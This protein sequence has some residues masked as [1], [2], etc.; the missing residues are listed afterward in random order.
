MP[1][2]FE[3]DF[4]PQFLNGTPAA[5][6]HQPESFRFSTKGVL[7]RERIKA[8]REL[9]DRGIVPIEPLPDRPVHVDISKWFLP[10]LGILSGTL[11]GLRQEGTPRTENDDL[12]FGFNVAGQCNIVQRGREISPGEGDAFLLNLAAGCFAISRP[13]LGHFVGLRVPRNAITPLVRD[14]DVT[15]PRSIPATADSAKLLGCYLGGL[16]RG[17]LLTIPETAQL[18]VTHVHDLI[19]LSLGAAGNAGGLLE[20]RTVAAV[21]LRAIKSDIVAHL[22]EQDLTI[23]AIAARHG[24]TPRYVHR[25]FEREGI[26]YTQFVLRQRLERAYRM[27]RDPRF[28]MWSIS[29]VAYEVGFGDL[30]YF[31]RA[32]RRH[33]QLTPSDVKDPTRR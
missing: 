1:C 29:A 28:A 14:I 25:L 27:L 10:G 7:P 24:V 15:T 20:E 31:N 6:V 3:A 19:A 18:V 12:F 30:S 11:C 22:E 5:M 33:Y 26:T 17:R 21:R 2:G 8:V 32:F 16:L 4:M 13:E 23:S 9:R